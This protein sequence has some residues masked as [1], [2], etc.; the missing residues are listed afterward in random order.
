M[1]TCR[2][3]GEPVIWARTEEGKAIPLDVEPLSASNCDPK[4]LVFLFDPDDDWPVTAAKAGNLRPSTVV[5]V[6]HFSTCPDAD[7]W[8]KPTTKTKGAK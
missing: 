3:C 8:R 2:T 7:T 6:S 4:S 5:Y 1:S